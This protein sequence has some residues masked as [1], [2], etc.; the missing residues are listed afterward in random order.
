[1]VHVYGEA[2]YDLPRNDEKWGYAIAP[3]ENS[4]YKYGTVYG[5]G[6]AWY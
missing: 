2:L 5:Y 1:M 3:V 4:S 6:E